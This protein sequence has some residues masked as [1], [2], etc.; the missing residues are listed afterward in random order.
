[1]VG[2]T[3]SLILTLLKVLFEKSAPKM[4]LHLT[5]CYINALAALSYL[6]L[7]S[8]FSPIRNDIGSCLYIPQRWLL[9]VWTAPAI[10][11]ILT[12]ISDYTPLMQLWVIL[13]NVFMLSAGGLA[14][15]PFISWPHKVF[16]YFASCAPFP[17]IL[18][19][20]W[21][22]VEASLVE[23]SEPSS[24]HSIKFIRLFSIT[25][26]NAFPVVYFVSVGGALPIDTIEPVWAVLDWVTKMVYS[27]SLMEANFFTIAQRRE[28]VIKAVEEAHRLRTIEQLS[29]AI[30]RKDNFLSTMSHELRTPLNGIIGLSDSLL[31]G[32]GGTMTEKAVN[33]VSTIGLSG[34]RLLQ[35]INDILDAAKM[36]QGIMVIK[37]ERVDIKRLVN[38]VLDLT[39]P[40]VRKGVSLVNTITN[41]PD[42]TGDTGRIVQIMY[43]LVGN[44]AKFTPT[45][46]IS[47]NAGAAHDGV[48]VFVSVSDTGVG[49]AKSKI[50]SIFG[51]FEQAH[52]GRITVDSTIGKGSTFTV[53]LPILQAVMILQD[54]DA[55]PRG[56]G[57][58]PG[59]L[60][61]VAED[62]DR[63]DDMIS[64][65]D[66]GI[67]M[68]AWT[69]GGRLAN[70]G[71]SAA[72]GIVVGGGNGDDEYA[73]RVHR[74]NS[75]NLGES[76]AHQ[77]NSAGSARGGSMNDDDDDTDASLLEGFR[78]HKP[79]YRERHGSCMVLSVDDDI[80]N[81]YVVAELLTLEGYKVEQAMSGNDALVFLEASSVLPDVVLLD[82]MMPDMNGYELCTKIRKRYS[83][84]SIPIIMVS[85]NGSPEDI[86]MGLDSGSVDYVKKPFNRQE[87]ISRVRAQIRNRE[88]FEVEMESRKVT[89]R[90]KSIMPM[91][92]INRLQAG[93]SMIAD[94][95]AEVTVLFADC[96]DVWSCASSGRQED[97]SE[98]ILL[99]N[100]MHSVFERLLAKYNVFRV[101]HT[102]NSYMVVSGHDGTQDHTK[103][104]LAVAQDMLSSTT[105]VRFSNSKPLQLRIGVHIGPAY[106]GVIGL[107]NPRYCVFGETVT[108]AAG[109]EVHAAPHTILVSQAVYDQAS[110]H[111]DR[112]VPYVPDL[113]VG[114]KPITTYLCKLGNW[115]SA[116]RNLPDVIRLTDIGLPPPVK[117]KLM[118]QLATM[119][120]ELAQKSEQ[121]QQLAMQ[122]GGARQEEVQAASRILE[123]EASNMQLRSRL[124][125]SSVVVA[126]GPAAAAAAAGAGAG[127]P[128][129][130]ASVRIITSSVVTHA[131]ASVP[132]AAASSAATPQLPQPQPQLP[133]SHRL[134]ATAPAATAV[135]PPI[136]HLG[137][138]SDVPPPPLDA[139]AYEMWATLAGTSDGG[140]RSIATASN[141]GSIN[142][143]SAI[144]QYFHSAGCTIEQLLMEIGL[145]RYVS[146][147]RE[148]E[149]TPLVLASMTDEDLK[150]IGIEAFGARRRLLDAA[151]EYSKR[152]S[153]VTRLLM[154]FKDAESSR[155]QEPMP[156]A[157]SLSCSSSTSDEELP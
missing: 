36:K 67:G 23:V 3:A 146:L 88:Y 117:D 100:K 149:V 91:S 96:V 107:S 148:Q 17:T 39:L 81:Q 43:N 56:G 106:A 95:H 113:M 65:G 80:I 128:G 47:I 19:H 33:T 104:I 6:M 48:H 44:A 13:L 16:W 109:L 156:T 70:K 90:L 27:S 38:D 152:L 139:A 49:I 68:H 111:N 112:F 140:S 60:S 45:G 73:H 46:T 126:D 76:G 51:A 93:K 77:H 29:K 154:Q 42:I 125:T 55:D 98:G 40:L 71:G 10:I 150:A 28:S 92:V 8:G 157:T 9:Y 26:W 121:Q 79:F 119:Q 61:S 64:I 58:V 20:M 89:E 35:L 97:I 123:L 74:S 122:L 14:T 115:E 63:G 54:G 83:A 85:A 7:W 101:E 4:V 133:L 24:R 41:V 136:Q 130:S 84:V 57:R 53:L 69:G 134:I 129:H 124:A 141:R 143:Q 12:N 105:T 127:H 155:P 118:A 34:K 72:H 59:W 99:I 145:P 11:F 142:T 62:E 110:S 94:Q 103:R 25:T 5:S 116:L 82:V 21:R 15:I 108:V 102:G 30:E 132:A 137:P 31:A 86:A 75:S 131:G 87:L 144:L 32:S 147:M 50:A 138:G 1:M 114:T 153:S 135:S 151:Q 66:G 18:V 2:Y 78:I 120:V 52:N 37:H 22:M